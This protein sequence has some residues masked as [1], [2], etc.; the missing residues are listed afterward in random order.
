[1]L[2]GSAAKPA[3]F[4]VT[5]IGPDASGR[6]RRSA[7]KRASMPS[8]AD[9][10]DLSD[11]ASERNEGMDLAAPTFQDSD[12][13]SIYAE[14]APRLQRYF[15]ARLRNSDDARDLVQETFARFLRAMARE[16]P[17]RPAAYLQ[18]I[19][20]NLLFNRTRQLKNQM[21][22]FHVSFDH[23]Y[24]HAMAPDQSERIEVEDMMRTYRR[25]LSELPE[26]TRAVFLLHR[27]EE[28][29]YREIG[30][31]LGISIPTVQYH[32]ARALAHI[33]ATLEQG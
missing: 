2:D 28:L 22:P 5:A 32:V 26:K 20:R 27:V 19:A 21:A 14:E 1:M 15:C 4:S 10:P 29:T 33:D 18:R 13:G 23:G 6:L 16:D 8:D 17:Q 12:I 24:E 3:S 25:A 31:R 7:R 11:V 9:K 30:D